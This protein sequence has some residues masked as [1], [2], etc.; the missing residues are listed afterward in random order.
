MMKETDSFA[1][2]LKELGINVKLPKKPDSAM[3]DKI[4]QLFGQTNLNKR[5]A[6]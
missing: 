3:S 4:S 2:G 5:K 1:P 6:S